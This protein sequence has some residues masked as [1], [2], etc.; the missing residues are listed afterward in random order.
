M[1]GYEPLGLS[2][3]EEGGFEGD[4]GPKGWVGGRSG[5]GE[6]DFHLVALTGKG[7]KGVEDK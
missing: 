5:S 6:H 4:A 1:Q 2:L 7:G 3:G